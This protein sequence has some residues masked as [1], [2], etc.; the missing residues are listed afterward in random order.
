[1]IN[2]E[3]PRGGAG[4]GVAILLYMSI[5]LTIEAGFFGLYKI[6]VWQMKTLAIDTATKIGECKIP[7]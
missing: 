5:G 6:E 2:A 1:M 7:R 4:T 3:Q